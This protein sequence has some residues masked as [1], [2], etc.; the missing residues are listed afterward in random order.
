[1]KSSNSSLVITGNVKAVAGL[2]I[3]S[4]TLVDTSKLQDKELN[5]L[6]LLKIAILCVI[7]LVRVVG[8]WFLLLNIVRKYWVVSNKKQLQNLKLDNGYKLVI[9]MYFPN[10][11]KIVR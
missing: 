10:R 6:T 3:A 4:K 2:G 11:L 9:F 5:K 8:G 7:P 1:M